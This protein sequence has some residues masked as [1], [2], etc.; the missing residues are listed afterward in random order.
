MKIW[1]VS[2]VDLINDERK[3]QKENGDKT[4]KART[5]ICK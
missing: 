5:R 4:G 2:S 3:Q 1:E